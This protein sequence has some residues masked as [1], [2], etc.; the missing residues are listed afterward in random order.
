MA[1]LLTEVSGAQINRVGFPKAR[2]FIYGQEVSSDVISVRVNQ[3]SGSL[4]RTPSTC[5][6]TLANYADKYLLNHRDMI[7]IGILKSKIND[8]WAQYASSS[9]IALNI[10]EDDIITR[11]NEDT[12]RV[13]VEI[14]S[15]DMSDPIGGKIPLSSATIRELAQRFATASPEEIYYQL[16]AIS[17]DSKNPIVLTRDDA[18]SLSK[19][20]IKER[21]KMDAVAISP[22]V[23]TGT[24][25][26]LDVPYGV[27][28]E[29]VA[30][31]MKNSLHCIPVTKGT[32]DTLYYGDRLIY[33]YP[34]MEGDCIFHPNDPVRVL[35]RDPFDPSIW[36]WQFTGFIDSWTEEQGLNKDSTISISC[37]DVSKMARYATVAVN[38]GIIKGEEIP[39]GGLVGAGAET[40]ANAGLILTSNLF[41]NLSIPD[42]L[43][44]LFFGSKSAIDMSIDAALNLDTLLSGLTKEELDLFFIKRY[45]S[46]L[47]ELYK[48]TPKNT[49][50]GAANTPN[51]PSSWVYGYPENKVAD[52]LVH[53]TT[54]KLN[55]MN[56][57]A[58]SS[59]RG[60]NFRRRN[61][62]MGLNYYVLGTR[63][64][65]DMSYNA[66]EVLDLHQWNEVIHHRVRQEDLNTMNKN[67]DSNMKTIDTSIEQVIYRIGT[68][69]ENYPVGG[70]QVYYF[71][72][73]SLFSIIGTDAFDSSFTGVGSV[74]SSFKDRLS[75]IYDLA[76]NIDWRFYATPKGDLVF[77]MPFYDYDP[78]EFWG[79]KESF[80]SNEG[81]FEQANA[82]QAYFGKDSILSGDI[83]SS[84]DYEY[85]VY[86]YFFSV[87]PVS[88]VGSVD[89]RNQKYNYAKE[90]TIGLWDQ[91][92]FSNTH[93]DQG[94]ITAYRSPYHLISGY[95]D[96]D[97]ADLFKYIAIYDTTLM[98]TLG[99]RMMEGDSWGFIDNA[100]ECEIYG[101]LQL[102][103]VN[104]NA[105]NLSID[106]APKFGMMVNRP[107][108]WMQRNYYGN[109]VSLSHSFVWKG[110]VSTSVNVNT[111]R[112]WSG[113]IQ[114]LYGGVY[115]RIYRH[116]MDSDRPFNF[117]L[118]LQKTAETTKKAGV[119]A[120][121]D[122]KLKLTEGA[123]ASQ[124]N[125]IRNM[126]KYRGLSYKLRE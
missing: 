112:A 29:V 8:T 65:S 28:A 104:A 110:D 52:I 54:S 79:S 68:D 92:G 59:P 81:V 78:D 103:K 90:F 60:V 40:G 120:L 62:T 97:N 109:I 117:Q 118:L 7:K 99:F 49:T 80:K 73:A 46:T 93:T 85:S 119:N 48:S 64:S 12:K 33:D 86:Q 51:N 83:D 50:E 22:G 87:K 26:D 96:T 70:G 15:V 108:Y 34:M 57:P 75:F 102:N 30:M 35:F 76:D 95:A 13:D 100:Y 3:A 39:I 44:T 66:I 106:I 18:I 115:R 114:E 98:P 111:I 67:I 9:D 101:A 24:W 45:N 47:E 31:K 2:V 61:A 42:I 105:K 16:Q 25:E 17:L 19:E 6:I 123:V 125:K 77:E 21:N 88:E 43:E 10:F 113:E 1:D 56:F 11:V 5:M 72:P 107:F 55:D 69:M 91:A 41:S 63:D 23:V 38:T 71:A 58:I 14:K 89:Y 37:T 84:F 36:Y 116:F 4:E 94:V 74:H 32:N 122:Q 27:K 20:I 126:R 121:T 124:R 53:T 82:S